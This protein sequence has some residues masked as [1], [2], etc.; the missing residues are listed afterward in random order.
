MARLETISTYHTPGESPSKGTISTDVTRLPAIEA[1]LFAGTCPKFVVRAT[2]Q[3]TRLWF[4][5][6][7]TIRFHVAYLAA[8]KAYSG[9]VSG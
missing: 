5:G 3:T 4:G 2:T 7:G 6:I 8:A 1:N 9:Y